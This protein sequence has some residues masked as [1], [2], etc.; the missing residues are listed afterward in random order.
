MHDPH[1]VDQ[2]LSALKAMS[3]TASLPF[4][5]H[6]CHATDDFN[7]SLETEYNLFQYTTSMYKGSKHI[8]RFSPSLYPINGGF[9]K[10]AGGHSLITDLLQAAKSVGNC[11]LVSNGYGLRSP[12][13]VTDV[14]L[15]L[16]D[17]RVLKCSNFRK[18][19][20]E[21]GGMS[22][23]L[24]QS[25]G[26]DSYRVTTYIGDKKNARGCKSSGIALKRR[27]STLRGTSCTCR[28]KFTLR[29]D[30]NSFFL[31]CGIGD[32][33]HTG[34]PP[35]LSNE[36]RNRKR[37]LDISTLETVAAMSVANIQPAQ[38]ALFTKTCTGQIFTRGQMAYVQGFTRM[39]KDFMASPNVNNATTTASESSP[40]E[41]MLSYL[42]KCGASYVCLY[43]HG[44][45]KELRG[46]SVK[47]ART[48]AIPHD[49]SGELT[50]LSVIPTDNDTDDTSPFHEKPVPLEV[51]ETSAFKKY[52]FES[53]LAVGAREDQDI[54]IA[55]C[56]VLPEGKRLFHAFPEVVCVDGT[57]ETNNES[58][59]LLTLSVKD[60]NAK[61]T[62]I[63]RC[64][65]PNERSWFF[66][67]LFQEALPVL[68]GAQSLHSVKLIMTDGDS[69]EMSQVDFAI[70]TYF[71]NAVRTRCGWHLV[72][73]GWRRNCKGLGYRRG[74]DDSAKRQVR[75]I[76]TWIYSWMRRGILFQDEYEM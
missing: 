49:L 64:F 11:A 40:C 21:Q 28:V 22:S 61:V 5:G 41:N 72:D 43:H 14:G 27:N 20:S 70:S 73:Q 25:T 3:W 66:R 23:T 30:H 10:D 24:N 17:Q 19:S 57:H 35:L 33:Q 2:T 26:T 67:W 62:V 9:R 8:I 59:P 7:A 75:V 34:H 56:W 76:K 74:K 47:A 45:S 68:L 4:K 42:Q 55:C 38:A 37:F 63:V 15:L 12:T 71:V 65:A 13:N 39:A 51:A 50:S 18:Y 31:V 36:I 53:R 1:P 58:R 48:E 16:T 6:F 52:A 44:K 32:N 60:S 54:L 46:N 29:I 69:Q